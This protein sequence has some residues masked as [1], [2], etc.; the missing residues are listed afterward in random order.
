MERCASLQRTLAV[1]HYKLRSWA[2]KFAPEPEDDRFLGF[3]DGP[4]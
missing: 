4:L 2:E 1:N 3:M